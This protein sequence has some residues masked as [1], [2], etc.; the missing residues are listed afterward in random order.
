MGGNG[1]TKT[2][3]ASARS[4]K[5]ATAQGARVTTYVTSNHASSA[6]PQEPEELRQSTTTTPTPTTPLRSESLSEELLQKAKA[7]SK[8]SSEQVMNDI[9]QT[10]NSIQ[11][12]MKQI[13]AAQV[14]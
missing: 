8:I 4:T 2:Q 11:R 14:S 1:E 6:V 5:V 10:M 7:N 13:S 9:N 3:Q 12:T